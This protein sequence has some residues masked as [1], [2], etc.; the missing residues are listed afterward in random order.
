[1]SHFQIYS[2]KEECGTL[3]AGWLF[4]ANTANKLRI[5]T[6]AGDSMPPYSRATVP[7]EDSHVKRLIAA[8]HIKVLLTGTDEPAPTKPAEIQGDATDTSVSVDST[9][10]KA[11]R[12]KKGLEQNSIPDVVTD[13]DA[14]QQQSEIIEQ[15]D[16]Q[17]TEESSDSDTSA[18]EDEQPVQ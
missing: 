12:K 8:G 2:S 13:V 3:F 15:V 5:V 14:E 16:N 10:K 11:P 1:M 7:A 17:V 18:T 6:S 4:V 9:P